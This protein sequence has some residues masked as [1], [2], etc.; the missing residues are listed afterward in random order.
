MTSD[1]IT[2]ATIAAVMGPFTLLLAAHTMR[3]RWR[4][5]CGDT[6]AVTTAIG[7]LA[8]LVLHESP[9][10]V[11]LPLL[12]LGPSA[13]VVDAY[14]G[15]LPDHLTGP[16]LGA[17]ALA[18]AASGGI[19]MRAIAI[20]VIAAGLAAAVI[21]VAGNALGWG[22]I[23][24]IPTLTIVLGHQGALLGGL[25][26]VVLLI[27]VTAVIVGTGTRGA[28]VP[29]GPALVFGTVGAAAGF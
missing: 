15:R 18:A 14:E 1:P 2:A 27:G 21:V 16:L 4:P 13:A 10:L 22:D 25:S 29:Y 11:L 17:T 6:A 9:P 28:V 23:K 7:V 3:T 12:V 24:L 19:G 26:Q 5:R 20:A 8:A